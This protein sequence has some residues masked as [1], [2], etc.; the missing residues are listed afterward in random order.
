MLNMPVNYKGNSLR[1]RQRVYGL[2]RL[3][4]KS[5]G[6]FSVITKDFE[7]GDR[8]KVTGKGHFRCAGIVTHSDAVCYG[9]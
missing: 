3:Y 7:P 1:V 6:R 9:H 8:A 4:D 5:H 2:R